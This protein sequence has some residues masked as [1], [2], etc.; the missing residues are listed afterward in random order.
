MAFVTSFPETDASRLLSE[1]ARVKR[2]QEAG[3]DV[4]ALMRLADHMEAM[5]GKGYALTVQ[6]LEA[7]AGD[8]REALGVGDGKGR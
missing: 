2:A 4:G 8:I 6:G 5:A 7:A 3:V 1:M